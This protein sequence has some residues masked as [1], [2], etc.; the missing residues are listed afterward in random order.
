MST[1]E[2]TIPNPD[3]E[4]TL[5]DLAYQAASAAK[6][7]S[8]AGAYA[9]DPD[10]TKRIA[11]TFAKTYPDM[12]RI[13]NICDSSLVNQVA[14]FLEVPGASPTLAVLSCPFPTAVG[15]DA[16]FAGTLGDTM[17]I[18]CPVTIK[19]SDIK[20][21]CVTVAASN[22]QPTLLNIATSTSDPIT[23]EGP[24]PDDGTVADP[25]GPDRIGLDITD[26]DAT[27]CIAA[28]PKVF[29]LTGGHKI[30]AG[31]PINVAT[32]DS[33]RNVDSV[34]DLEE[35]HMWY[36][37]MRYG[38]V[39]LKNFSIHSRDTLFIY[40]QIDKA[41]FIP[42]TNFV[43]KFTLQPTFL[44]PNDLVYHEVTKAVLAAKEKAFIL[45]GSTLA[46]QTLFTTPTKQSRAAEVIEESPNMVTTLLQ[47]LT[48]A[49]TDNSSKT[50]T[51]TEREHAKEATEHQHFYEILF[52]STVETTNDEGTKTKYFKKATVDPMFVQVLKTNK[53][54]KATRL[55]QIAIESMAAE[56]NFRENRFASASSLEA[57]MFDQ[58]LTAAIRT[59]QWEHQHTVIHPEGIKTHFGFHHLAPPRTWSADY[60]TRLEGAIKVVQ[61]EQVEE[62]T[63]RTSAKATELYHLGR[64]NTLGEINNNIGNFYTMMHTMI[65]VDE[66]NPPDLW[67]EVVAFDRIMRSQEGRKWF[68]LHRNLKELHFNV[69]QD[70]QSTIAGFVAVARRPG[71]KNAV[72]NG[73]PI[74]PEIFTNAKTQGESDLG[75]TCKRQ[76]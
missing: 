69:L 7:N 55:M 28:F 9:P 51:S 18:I 29:L 68:E 49:I 54:S 47:G 31:V 52:A 24:D 43:S 15:T 71:Y 46:R 38:T 39:N 17:D 40:E 22:V 75:T 20:G 6:L 44:T 5:R 56:M 57:E 64:T 16:V 27:P 76:S 65:T 13:A 37:G 14:F 4:P 41:Q 74:S 30:P 50:M 34:T 3:T 63:S 53:N 66:D 33:L 58:P 23:E 21:Y 48:T 72:M 35:F 60:K 67:K 12:S 8:F 59:A 2:A 73:L 42:E 61:Q 62:A 32:T 70:I 11:A 26:P 10:K 45:F 25:P 19:M 1:V 36:E